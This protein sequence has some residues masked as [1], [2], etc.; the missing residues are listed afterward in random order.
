MVPVRLSHQVLSLL[1]IVCFQNIAVNF[2]ADWKQ[3]CILYF[4]RI[5]VN[6]RYD[7]TGQHLLFQSSKSLAGFFFKY[8][9]SGPSPDIDSTL[10]SS[11]ISLLL[12]IDVN[13]PENVCVEIFIKGRK[14]YKSYNAGKSI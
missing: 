3:S 9:L 6:S 1:L 7:L 12:S 10:V 8:S 5:D 14:I 4:T 11:V 13:F 2:D